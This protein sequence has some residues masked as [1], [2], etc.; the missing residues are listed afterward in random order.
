MKVLFVASGNK[1]KINSLI[2]AQAESLEKVGIEIDFFLIQG[3]GI[4]G[5]L[6]NVP[7]LRRQLKGKH[8]QIVHAHY[9]F[10]GYVATLA[11]TRN[12]VVSLMG[13][14]I[15]NNV[16]LQFSTRIFARLFWKATI[17]KSKKMREDVQIKDAFVVPNGVNLNQFVQI[18]Q[19]D[20]QRNLKWDTSK[21]HLLFAANPK[22][23]EK[24]FALLEGALKGIDASEISLHTLQ[25]VPFSEMNMLYNACDGVLLSS[26]WEGSPNVIKEA[27][28]CNKPVVCTDVGD[29]K[30]NFGSVSGCFISGFEVDDYADKIQQ[31]LEFINNKKDVNGLERIK[32]L[33]ISSNKIAEK[34]LIIYQLAEK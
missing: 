6:K 14:D 7:R 5:Y 16:I 9:S 10:C 30:E 2:K 24:N 31:L 22:R 25:D 18:Y 17:V 11:G 28:A 21:V 12:L 33:E 1:G 32:E 8:Y 3:K 34:I 27:M 29:V 26:L 23:K 4:I 20:A 19:P 13:S 15:K